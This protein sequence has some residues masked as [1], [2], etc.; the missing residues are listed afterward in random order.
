MLF[1]GPYRVPAAA[2]SI[3]ADLLQHRRPHR[4]SRALAVRVPGPR[5]AAR[6][7]G[8]DRSTSTP[9]NS[10]DA[11]CCAPTDLP[12]RQP[13]RHALQRRR[14]RLE[15]F[16]QALAILDYD[17][18][19]RSRHVRAPRVATSASVPA[20]TSSRRR[21][22]R[23]STPPRVRRFASS[24]PARSTSTLPADRAGNSLETTVVQLTADALGV[25]IADVHTI[26]GDTAIT[27]FGAGTG[28]S[29][30]GSMTAGAVGET[31]AVAARP[32]PRHRRA[33][34]RSRRSTTSSSSTVAPPS[35]AS[36]TSG[37]SLAEIAD[38]AYF[39]AETLPSGRASWTRSPAAATIRRPR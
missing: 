14:R 29:R 32:D 9:S 39:Q 34:A 8:T 36:R 37:S 12:H 5:D 21:A 22:R 23:R 13:Q 30:S 17:A 28:G 25:D 16:E 6:H 33:H 2:F 15:T 3:E 27:P 38:I 19:R 31:A 18:F 24:R 20:P 26:Q 4:V 7:R 35:A 10:G 11:T 1:P